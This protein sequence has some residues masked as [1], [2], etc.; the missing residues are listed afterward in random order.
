MGIIQ[1]ALEVPDDILAGLMR[2]ELSRFGS[3][4]RDST[5]IITHLKEVTPPTDEVSE[6]AE[7][8]AGAAAA[9]LKNHRVLIGLGIAVVAAAAATGVAVWASK[10]RKRSQ[11]V[12]EVVAPVD[13]YNAALVEYLSAI[14]EGRLEAENLDRLIAALD[15][16]KAE[17]DE[18]ELSITL[19]SEQADAL[20]ELVADYSRKLAAANAIELTE[21]D[22]APDANPVVIMRDWLATQRETLDKAA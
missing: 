14:Q 18:G 22:E 15:A 17:A 12:P 8:A 13:E 5:E 7:A 6:V 20:V 11:E 10:R 16:V 2:G 4:V 3:V 9:A 19:A 1:V 21:P